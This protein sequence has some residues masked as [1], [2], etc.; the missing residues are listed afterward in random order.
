MLVAEA[1]LDRRQTDEVDGAG[2]GADQEGRKEE[3]R[4]KKE[5]SLPGL[6]AAVQWSSVDDRFVAA[7]I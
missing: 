2:G 3:G 4:A 5:K 7:S 6:P 1:S